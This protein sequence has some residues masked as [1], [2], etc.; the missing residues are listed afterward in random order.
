LDLPIDEALVLVAGRI[1]R[2]KGI[3]LILS[4]FELL[5]LGTRCPVLVVAGTIEPAVLQDS[6]LRALESLGKLWMRNEYIS[7]SD[8]ASLLCSADVVLVIRDGDEGPSGV[9][10]QAAACGRV[11]V[12]AGSSVLADAVVRHGLGVAAGASP[13]ALAR[14]IEL[15]LGDLDRLEERLKTAQSTLLDSERQFAHALLA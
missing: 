6:R 11:V 10:A 12:T 8:F 2:R 7:T 13:E 9:L 15:A 4:T 3:D 5:S 14:G 1:D